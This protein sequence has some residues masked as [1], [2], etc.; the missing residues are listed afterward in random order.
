MLIPVNL[1]AHNY[2]GFSFS[3]EFFN[4]THIP[5]QITYFDNTKRNQYM[6]TNVIQLNGSI[7]TGFNYLFRSVKISHIKGDQQS[8]LKCV[9]DCDILH[10]LGHMWNVYHPQSR[11]QLLK[12]MRRVFIRPKRLH[13]LCHPNI[14]K[15]II[16]YVCSFSFRIIPALIPA[17]F[18]D[19]WIVIL[20]LVVDSRR[21]WQKSIG[22]LSLRNDSGFQSM[23]MSVY[24]G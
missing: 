8:I 5:D 19:K 9:F 3:L 17:H 24:C 7:Q 22:K 23:D 4:K 11:L 2:Y 1:P 18:H 21:N 14:M 16:E 15:F 10:T 12:E 20:N 6:H 13:R